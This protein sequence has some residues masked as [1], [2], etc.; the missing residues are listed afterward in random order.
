MLR[1]R[2][3]STLD[4]SKQD[5]ARRESE[6]REQME[7]LERM[8]EEAPKMAQEITHQ[9]QRELLRRASEGSNRLDVSMA[10]QDTRYGELGGGGYRRASLRKERRDGRIIFLVLMIALAAAIVWLVTHLQLF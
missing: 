8:I 1:R 2:S 6:L 7:K 4:Q 5:L 3:P 9:Q 10:L